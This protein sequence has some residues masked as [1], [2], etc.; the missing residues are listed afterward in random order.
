MR[1][2]DLF[3]FL[4]Q[5]N[6]VLIALSS[7]M[8][9]KSFIIHPLVLAG[10]IFGICIILTITLYS[11]SLST[12]DSSIKITTNT[13]TTLRG[14]VLEL[15]SVV[16]D[17]R[18]SIVNIVLKKLPLS[19]SSDSLFINENDAVPLSDVLVWDS[20][21]LNKLWPKFESL[22]AG[23]QIDLEICRLS[24]CS[25][26]LVLKTSSSPTKS[27]LAQKDHSIPLNT[28]NNL[29]KTQFAQ[30]GDS[31]PLA[32][33]PIKSTPPV[34]FKLPGH[35][36][37]EWK[38]YVLFGI[39]DLS[40]STSITSV[41]GNIMADYSGTLNEKLWYNPK[42]WILSYKGLDFWG[43]NQWIAYEFEVSWKTLNTS[44]GMSLLSFNWTG[45]SVKYSYFDKDGGHARFYIGNKVNTLSG[46]FKDRSFYSIVFEINW[47][48]GY[49]IS[50]FDSEWNQ[51]WHW[52]G[53][54]KFDIWNTVYIGSTVWLD[55]WDWYIRGFSV[56]TSSL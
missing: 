51:I 33:P 43:K 10:I 9:K 2:F 26:K 29:I 4:I 38:W 55:V 1:I 14:L 40:Q 17:S 19:L 45:S 18:W 39:A 46:R 56:H 34:P 3:G 54:E 32:S 49:L 31:T 52:A 53:K 12:R 8:K 30:K 35:S 23:G 28:V 16:K 21:Y 44:K 27:Q 50:I 41:S 36:Y 48:N 7:S 5:F 20:I 47:D 13:W 25:R 6:L 15:D 22:L 42:S 11:P 24:D 37:L